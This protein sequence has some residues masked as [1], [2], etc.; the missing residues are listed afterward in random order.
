M[1]GVIVHE[2]LERIGGAEKVVDRMAALY[3][4]AQIHAMWNDAPGRFEEGRVRETWL[5]RSPL[6][7]RKAAALPLMPATWRRLP[8]SSADWV[9]CSSHLFAH[10]ARFAGPSRDAPKFV[11]TYTPA[12][13]IWEPELDARGNSAPARLASAA[14]KPLDRRRAQEAHSIAGISEFVRE[15]IARNWGVDSQVI[16]PPVDVDA[17]TSPAPLTSEEQ[18]LI[19][20]LP[21]E[22]IL[23][24]SRFVKYKRLDLVINAG[25]WAGVPVVLAGGGPEEEELRA[26]A[27]QHGIEVRFISNPS[28][29]L[30]AA[31]YRRSIAFMFPA[32]EDFGIMPVEAMAAGAPVIGPRV[33]GVSETVVDGVSGVLVDHFSPE[34]VRAAVDAASRLDRDV[35]PARARAFSNE[36]FDRNL[37][38]WLPQ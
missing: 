37:Q 11:Y 6:R 16:Y 20:T 35:I 7:G 23:G 17:F 19:A 14:L 10:H 8:S 31:L 26:A 1:T 29:A 15:R 18:S 4:D 12:R 22:Y 9:L 2:W 27:A 25:L 30:L 5:A 13:Y 38:E 36:E 24:A 28:D 32:I 21:G 3:P 34:E 33:G